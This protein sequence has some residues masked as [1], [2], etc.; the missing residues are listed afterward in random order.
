MS[1]A[2]LV[3][4]PSGSGKSSSIERLDP[5]TTFVINVI[6]KP[7][8]FKGYKKRYIPIEGWED[9]TGNYYASDDWQRIIKC[10]RMINESR[11]EITTV[12]IDDW[13]FLMSGEFMRRV[14]EKGYEKFS[15]LAMHAWSTISAL[16]S[17]RDD[18]T[19]FILTHTDLDM[20]GKSKAKTIG[21]LLDE[22]ITVEAMFTTVLQSRIIDGR[23]VFQTQGDDDH[24]AKSPRGLFNEMF[25]DN[26]LQDV[27]EKI[28]SYFN[29]EE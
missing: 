14:S 6:S 3:M 18:L 4:G 26:D 10:L 24:I 2:V 27:K 22:K 20:T 5:S 11:P 17:C 29:E 19:G 23:Y 7:L 13:Q 25:I 21:K 12:V 1:N 16:V 9:T 28:E 15:E 8:P